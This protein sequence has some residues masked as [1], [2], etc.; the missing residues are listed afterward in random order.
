[1]VTNSEQQLKE[2]TTRVEEYNYENQDLRQK[3]SEV[4]DKYGAVD[5]DLN[6]M[7]SNFEEKEIECKELQKSTARLLRTCSEQEKTIA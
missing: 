3:L 4:E 5:D 1:M 6:R 7:K 2:L